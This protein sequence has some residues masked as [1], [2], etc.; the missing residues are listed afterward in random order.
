[1]NLLC[2]LYSLLTAVA[3]NC[4]GNSNQC[5]SSTP[6]WVHASLLTAHYITLNKRAWVLCSHSSCFSIGLLTVSGHASITKQYTDITHYLLW[7]QDSAEHVWGPGQRV[8][9]EPL[10]RSMQ[11][12]EEEKLQWFPC[13]CW[14][15]VDVG[16][17]RLTCAVW[18]CSEVKR[19]RWNL[20]ARCCGKLMFVACAANLGL[21]GS[22]RIRGSSGNRIYSHYQQCSLWH[23]YYSI[24][25]NI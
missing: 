21:K 3:C 24:Q 12:T 18:L 15:V 13:F 19:Q 5:A 9:A 7:N 20:D 14:A 23:H 17:Q 16:W 4:Y 25:L 10:S 11:N 2:K 22:M 6:T 1:M 8:R